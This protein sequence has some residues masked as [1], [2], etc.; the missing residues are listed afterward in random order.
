MGEKMY[1]KTTIIKY[2]DF[3]IQDEKEDKLHFKP[4][5]EKIAEGILKYNQNQTLILSIEGEW[6]SGKTSLMNLIKNKTNRVK[7]KENK[8]EI[9]H[10]SP[11]LLTDINQVIKL[12]FDD[13]I[14]VLIH[15]SFKAKWNEEI[16]R[17]IQNFVNKL[18]PEE[19][20]FKTPLLSIKYK[21]R[22]MFKTDDNMSLEKIKSKI[23]EYLK[24]LDKKIVIV[25]DDIDRLTDKE[26]EFIFRLTKGI[27]DFDNLIYILLYDKNVITKSLQLFKSENGEK[28]LEKI[29]QYPIQV[30]KANNETIKELL[31]EKIKNLLNELGKKVNFDHDKEKWNYFEDSVIN[32]FIKNIRDVNRLM[33]II[34]FEYPVIAENINFVDF[35]LI[36]LIRIKN[37]ELYELI[38][39]K[40][41][42]ILKHN[43]LFQIMPDDDDKEKFKKEYQDIFNKYAEYKDIL[44]LLFPSLNE[45]SFGYSQESD[46]KN[47]KY[48]E[49]ID[50]FE[51]Y[52]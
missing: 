46:N 41:H 20:T 25:I 10:F 26:I 28:Y 45:D 31:N 16:K 21:I 32:N 11:W 27:A 36:S 48:L 1:D 9:M 38:K 12:F 7:E 37:I 43:K 4:F 49:N 50:Y 14:K 6:G 22:N 5:A 34:S 13:L 2:S 29:V 51:N 35:F 33:S 30:P 39:N 15:N 40:F 3:P 8:I 52:M 19:V 17:D 23:N 44:N 24:E 47:Y 18:L 42:K